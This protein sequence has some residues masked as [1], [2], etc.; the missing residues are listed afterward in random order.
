MLSA[1]ALW[2]LAPSS[3]ALG[4]FSVTVTGRSFARNRLEAFSY[5][6]PTLSS[7]VDRGSL[8][9]RVSTYLGTQIDQL[10]VPVKEGPS[11][12]VARSVKILIGLASNL[13]RLPHHMIGKTGESGTER[14]KSAPRAAPRS[15][16]LWKLSEA[17]RKLTGEMDSTLQCKI[18]G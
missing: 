9:S 12:V 14:R 1:T 16:R 15:F 13:N 10:A 6:N 7:H 3:T 2:N 18:S 17:D 11:Q 4:S 8:S 5:N